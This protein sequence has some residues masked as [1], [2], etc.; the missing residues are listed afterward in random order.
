[1]IF[2][3]TVFSII[4]INVGVV[5]KDAQV[6]PSLK[7]GIIRSFAWYTVLK[8]CRNVITMPGYLVAGSARRQC[9]VRR[10]FPKNLEEIGQKIPDRFWTIQNLQKEAY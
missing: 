9:L 3:R 5:W 2:G 4:Q 8:L 1:V 10:E 7:K 6:E